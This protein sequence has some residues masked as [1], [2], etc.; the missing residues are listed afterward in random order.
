MSVSP[1]YLAL[2]SSLL[3]ALAF[4]DIGEDLSDPGWPALERHIFAP[5]LAIRN[6]WVT[7]LM[8]RLTWLGSQTT[9]LGLVLLGCCLSW[10]TPRPRDK[11]ALLLTGLFTSL[12]NLGLKNWFLRARPGPE[13]LPLVEEPYYS[14]PSGH[15]MISLAVYGFL[16]YLAWRR[17]RSTWLT[18]PLLGL[19]LAIA[20]SRI[21][22]AVHYPGDVLAG[23]VAGWPCLCL[24][25][26][27][28]RR[29]PLT[30]S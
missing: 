20:A 17:L 5:F 30:K 29:S 10:L 14:F 28:H 13:L 16:A 7:G 1:K 19:V 23:L 4:S 24:G 22:L 9:L 15:A 2:V 27:L 12:L 3:A 8:L 18:L 25:I 6:P 11:A 21:Y 26:A